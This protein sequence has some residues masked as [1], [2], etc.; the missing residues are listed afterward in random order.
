MRR[1]ASFVTSISRTNV[2][3]AYRA[4]AQVLALGDGAATRRFLMCLATVIPLTLAA[5]ASGGP[6][7]LSGDR[8]DYNEAISRS[9]KE[10]MLTNIVRFRYLDFPVFMAVSSVITSYSYE[11]GVGVSGTA[12]LAEAAARVSASMV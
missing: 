10:Q 8:F 9:S 7:R 1:Y 3:A 11:G 2:I 4:L 12:G 5:C 6:K